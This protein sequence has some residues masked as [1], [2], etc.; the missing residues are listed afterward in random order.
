[1][2]Q[3]EM[4]MVVCY[5]VTR[6]SVRVK[7]A[8]LLEGEL[9]RVQ[10]SVFEGRMSRQEAS[11]LGRRCSA[12]LGP[13]DSL[14]IYAVTPAGLRQSQVFGLQPLPEAQEFWLI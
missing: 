14:R 9:V 2:A 6:D 5:D 8:A 10:K 12:L 13:D 7:L 1:M 11:R 4:L 3:R